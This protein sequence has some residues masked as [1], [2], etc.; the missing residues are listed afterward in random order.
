MDPFAPIQGISLERYADLSADV[1]DH[2]NDPE[3]QARIVEAQGVS[4]ADWEAAKNGWTARMQDFSLMGRVAQ[5]FMP[6]YQSALSRKKGNVSVSFDDFVAMAGAMKALGYERMF[7]TYGIDQGTWTQISGHWQAM[8]QGN[9]M[10]YGMAYSQGVEREGARI[11]QGGQPRP[12]SIQK[13]AAG[14]GGQGGQGGQ[15][16]QWTAGQ[17]GAAPM[18][19][20]QNAAHAAQRMENQ[21]MGAAV[22]QNVNAHIAAAQA[23]AAAAYGQAAQNMGFM[24]RGVMGMVGMG[25]IAKGIGP[26]MGVLVQWSDGNR[27]PGSVVQVANG[28][29][30]VAFGN[31]QQQ[32][33]PES[34]V[35]KQ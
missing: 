31:G 11:A 29:V 32:W 21:M 15:P 35:T 6:M 17:G 16:Q 24:G 3:A 12:V 27:Y 2:T 5:A 10:Q 7:A 18:P 30:L 13:T 22:Q 19:P 34:A 33:V 26:G 28:Q 25:A 1:S 4:R 20:A 9:P 8:M 23:Q 14:Q